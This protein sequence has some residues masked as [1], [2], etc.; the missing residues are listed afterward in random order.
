MGKEVCF[1]LATGWGTYYQLDTDDK[2]GNIPREIKPMGSYYEIFF[3]HNKFSV[4]VYAINYASF[5]DWE[6]IKK[7]RDEKVKKDKEPSTVL[8]LVRGG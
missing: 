6:R 4:K 8:E 2:S 5:G 7:E 3:T 1:E